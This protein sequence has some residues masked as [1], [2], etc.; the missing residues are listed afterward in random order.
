MSIGAKLNLGFGVLVLL[1]MV[2][3]A[4]SYVA[5][6]RAS[7]N[8]TRTTDLRAPSTLVSSRAQANL[9]KMLADVRGYLALGDQSYREGYEQSR[10]AFEENLRSLGELMQRGPGAYDRAG[11]PED[12]GRKLA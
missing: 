1:T 7:T 9:L 10:A 6:E 8:M 11:A 3:I 4:L 5:S 2:V 12:A